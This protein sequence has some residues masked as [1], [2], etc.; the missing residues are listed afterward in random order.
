MLAPTKLILVAA[1]VGVAVLQCSEAST[2]LRIHVHRQRHKTAW[3]HTHKDEEPS[4]PQCDVDNEETPIGVEGAEGIFC[5]WGQACVDKYEGAC[6]AP[7]PGLK[8]GSYCDEVRTG[9]MACIAYDSMDAWL[10]DHPEKSDQDE[11]VENPDDDVCDVDN[12]ET[13]MSVEGVKGVFCVSG[14]A[15]VDKY[16]GACP[17]PQPGLEFGSYCDET[18]TG[19][20][21]CKPYGSWEE[22]HADHPD[23]GNQ[24]D[25]ED[26]SEDEDEVCDLDNEETPM[27]V[28]GVKGV[29]CVSGQA[30]ADKYDGACPPPQP[31]LEFGS[32]CDEVMTGVMGCKPYTSM[33]EWEADHGEKL[34]PRPRHLLRLR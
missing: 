16:D 30:C 27:S 5:V 25:T 32:Y 24:G 23:V 11:M 3:E 21:G 8:F 19:V 4:E 20:M 33:K 6:P 12:E 14:Q 17:M 7:Q 2:V 26:R 1:A 29:F 9:V 31:G 10:A 28:E 13:P 22:F 15:C 34:R 18:Q